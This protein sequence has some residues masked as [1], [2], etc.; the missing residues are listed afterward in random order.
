MRAMRLRHMLGDRRMGAT[1]MT[2]GV[3]SDPLIFIKAFDDVG[4][5][6]QLDFLADQSMRH[7]IKMAFE[8]EVIINRDASFL[9]LCV[10]I[11][12]RRQRL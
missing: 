12:M 11:A 10:L 8:L 6:A 3:A 7:T 4:S 5:D 2:A 9:L 1:P